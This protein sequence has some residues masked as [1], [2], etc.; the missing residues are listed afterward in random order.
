MGAALD[1]ARA[2]DERRVE[3]LDRMML[4]ERAS[5]EAAAEWAAR[6]AAWTGEEWEERAK[7]ERLVLRKSSESDSGYNG[8]TKMVSRKFRVS[9][10]P[11]APAVEPILGDRHPAGPLQPHKPSPHGTRR[12]PLM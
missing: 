6:T 10:R 7:L 11:S 5:A 3:R 8:V 12:R 9:R 1:R 2:A 4:T